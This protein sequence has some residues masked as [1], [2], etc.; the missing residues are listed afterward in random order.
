MERMCI[1]K[2]LRCWFRIL[3]FGTFIHG[4][5]N[6]VR[7]ATCIHKDLLP[8]DAIVTHDYLPRP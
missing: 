5:E 2:L 4:N 7:S 1:S 3:F 6:A 8:E